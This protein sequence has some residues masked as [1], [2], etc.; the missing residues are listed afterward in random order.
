MIDKNSLKL[1]LQ[2]FF[3]ERETSEHREQHEWLRERIEVER[4]RKRMFQVVTK[5]ALGWSVTAVLTA[6]TAWVFTGNWHT[7]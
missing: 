5:T 2:E 6:I 1:V 4:E 3:D 7:P